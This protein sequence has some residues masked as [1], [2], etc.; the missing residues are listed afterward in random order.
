MGY[1]QLCVLVGKDVLLWQPL[2]Q[3]QVAGLVWHVLSLPLPEHLLFQLPKNPEEHLPLLFGHFGGLQN[4]SRDKDDNLQNVLN[5]VN[6]LY[7][8]ET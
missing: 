1:E 2:H 3:L 8:N 7:P 6:L 4:R 5:V